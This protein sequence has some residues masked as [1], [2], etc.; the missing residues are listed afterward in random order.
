MSRKTRSQSVQSPRV[1]VSWDD[2]DGEHEDTAD[3]GVVAEL[4]RSLDGQDRTHVSLG[5]PDAHLVCGGSADRGLVL[6]AGLDGEIHQLLSTTPTRHRGSVDVVAAGQP[7]AY[8]ARFVVDLGTA[9]KAA[10][11]FVEDVGLE[12]SVDWEQ[13]E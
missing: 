3:P 7:G 10:R 8:P 4:I 12:S 11:A 1:N 2:G 13:Q 5:D 6:Y 9:L